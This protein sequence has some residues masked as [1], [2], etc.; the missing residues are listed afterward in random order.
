M[1]CARQQQKNGWSPNVLA[2]DACTRASAILNHAGSEGSTG[3]CSKC[4]DEVKVAVGLEMA[5]GGGDPALFL[6]IYSYV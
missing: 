6:S 1:I 4:S 5:G 3:G 2:T